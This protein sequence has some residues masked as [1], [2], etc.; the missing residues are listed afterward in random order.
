MIESTQLVP[1]G[2]PATQALLA[3][4]GAAQADDPLA[5][6]TVI[7][8]SNFVGLSVRRLIGSDA[9]RV[10]QRAGVAN[11]S[12]V[13]PFQLAEHVA[14][15]LLLETR[16]IT[17]PVLG[18]AV[19]RALADEPGPYAPVADHEATQQALA[20]LFADLSNVDEAGLESILDT[21]SQ[22]AT[23]AVGFYRAIAARLT[24]F[25]TERD[26]A[27]AAATRDDLA[28]RL[29]PF[30]HVVWYLPTPATVSLAD[31]IGRVLTDAI[32]SSVVVGVS[33]VGEADESVIRTCAIAGVVAPAKQV[34]SIP[35]TAD[36]II[37]VT[38]AAEEARET[39]ARVL[40]LIATGTAPDRIG[41]FFPTPDPYV[42][43]IEQQFDAA[44]VAVNGPDPRRLADSVAGRVLLG[45]LEL[46]TERWRRDRVI[47]LV[48]AG[49]LRSGDERV[50][51]TAWDELSR[52]AGVIAD[53]TD[54]RVKLERY[55]RTIEARLDEIGVDPGERSAAWRHRRLTDRL[56][57]IQRLR[58]FVDQT[59]AAIASVTS[60][61]SWFDR[62]AAAAALLTT[63]LGA[64]HRHSTWPESEREA[65][66]RVEAALA[67]L[68]TLDDIEP[69]PSMDVFVRALRSE[70][71][72]ARGRRG[73]F[74]HGVMYGP[75]ASALG[76]DLDAVFVLGAAEG[77]LP[78]PR[79][80]DA[81]L[82]EQLRLDS[83]DQLESKSARLHHQHRAFLAALSSAPPG[84]RTVTFPRG[85][86]RSSRHS[87]PSR[88][89]LDSVSVL[90][91]RTVHATEFETVADELGDE[92][93]RAVPSFATGISESAMSTSIEERDLVE[94]A[95]ASGA[96]S[97]H[98]LAALVGRGLHMQLARRSSDFTEFDGNLAGVD[99]S[100]GDRPVSPSR[101]ETWSSCGLRYF[102]RYVLDV[103]DRDDPE[104]TD[105]LSALDRGSLVHLVL[106]RFIEE[107]IADGPPEPTAPWS[108]EDRERLH[109]IATEIADEYEVSG[110]TGR[111]INW[112]VQRDDLRDVLDRF[113]R[114]DDDFRRSHLATPAGVELDL[115]VR[116]G[117]PVDFDLGNGRRVAMRGLIDRIDTTVD[118]RVIVS[119]YKTGRGTKFNG[120][121]A[122][123]F[124]GGTTLQLGMYS[125]GAMR[126]TQREAAS[127]D[128]WLVES[129]GQQRIGY[130]WNAALRARFLELLAAI[131]D[132]IDSGVFAASPGEWNTFR[133][134]NESCAY[135]DY[136]VVCVRERG[137]QAEAK[138]GA[139]EVQVRLVLEAADRDRGDRS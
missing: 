112:R 33:G 14:A 54:W 43:I 32:S 99:T 102:F 40:E 104:R 121:G 6:V 36:R 79:R 125:E 124:L 84:R 123:P 37:S 107:S 130:A 59:A 24:G 58:R 20:G 92:V 109:A 26:L 126:H 138:A 77:L 29:V 23:L 116:T 7:V 96:P 101:L 91:G 139:P 78:V 73:R 27:V 15:D 38:D 48:S 103:T 83:L 115:G 4:I 67:R 82:P 136:D 51:P 66:G 3:S 57:D 53:L 137:E 9:L 45:A 41:I 19:R 95:R 64:E 61:Q 87:L 22:Q 86:L 12:F 89:L 13:T 2:R 129:S 42:R 105:E 93:F 46:P 34:A 74:G 120:I 62:C 88:W 65:F 1:Y 127:A 63:L 117:E 10:G 68:A 49:P 47:A 21:G 134:T 50:R 94:L 111:A 5:P 122:D 69:A 17:N 114:A 132:G 71:D 25:H 11:V 8:P 18:A 135:C 76:H 70:L 39:C 131:T 106:E 52:D 80:D 28:M 44:G 118:G 81:V 110:R 31:F 55:G 119:D 98:P 35:A 16:P 56:H 72:V 85:S 100:S 60:S 108:E 128:Y 75:I 113:L 30:G 133:Q 90:A 97:E